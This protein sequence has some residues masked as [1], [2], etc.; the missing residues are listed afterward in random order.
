MI[1]YVE[2]KNKFWSPDIFI[3]NQSGRDFG[4]YDFPPILP[5]YGRN[6]KI[7]EKFSMGTNV[8]ENLSSVDKTRPWTK[9]IVVHDFLNWREILINSLPNLLKKNLSAKIYRI[10]MMKCSLG[11]NAL[12]CQ[13]REPTWCQSFKTDLHSDKNRR[14]KAV[15]IHGTCEVYEECCTEEGAANP[16]GCSPMELDTGEC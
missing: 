2:R 16:T 1:S 13:S 4:A 5:L 15:T 14:W 8:E 9:T 3:V 11:L 10:S 12:S 6:P 7:D